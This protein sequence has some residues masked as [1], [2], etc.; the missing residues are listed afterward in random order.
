MPDLQGML[1]FVGAYRHELVG[2][3]VCRQPMQLGEYPAIFVTQHP[4][5]V[6]G[7]AAD[8]AQRTCFDGVLR[9]NGFPVV[10]N[11]PVVN[12]PVVNVLVVNVSS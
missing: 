7:G 2:P 12:V 8:N 6:A 11:V 10:V 3:A 1:Y 4:E 9:H 5:V